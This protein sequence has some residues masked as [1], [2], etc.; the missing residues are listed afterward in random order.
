MQAGFALFFVVS[1]TEREERGVMI[2]SDEQKVA[3]KLI[4]NPQVRNVSM[5][6]LI[7]EK[8]GWA[9]HV[10]RV[11]ELGP[12]GHTPRHRHPWPHINYILEGAG[13]L[14]VDGR[15]HSLQSG[16]YAYVPAGVEHQFK[17]SGRGEFRFI[18]IVPKEG[19]Q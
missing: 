6:V 16:S 17:N 12:D 2:V 5:K 7:S 11:F 1:L 15:E 3:A 19:H 4:D 13:T 8:E 10:M 9:D 14:F 18:C